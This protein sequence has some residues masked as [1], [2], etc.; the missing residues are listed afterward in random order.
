[1]LFVCFYGLIVN[2]TVYKNKI[3]VAQNLHC[4]IY[5]LHKGEFDNVKRKMY[6]VNMEQDK[7]KGQKMDLSIYEQLKIAMKRKGQSVETIAQ[8]L[9]CSRQNLNQKLLRHNMRVED[10]EQIAQILGYDLI[11]ELKEKDA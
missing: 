2:P 3:K 7:R 11:I 1:M 9:G 8:V 4:K 6:L 5:N 10:L